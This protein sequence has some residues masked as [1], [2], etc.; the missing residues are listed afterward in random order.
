MIFGGTG[1]AAM[2]LVLAAGL[3][4]PGFAFVA[5]PVN[6]QVGANV[7]AAS[8]DERRA[9]GAY[10]QSASSLATVPNLTVNQDFGRG[11]TAIISGA[12]FAEDPESHYGITADGLDCRIYF[13]LVFHDGEEVA[14]ASFDTQVLPNGDLQLTIDRSKTPVPN[15]RTIN[16]LEPGEYGGATSFTFSEKGDNG[17]VG[18]HVGMLSPGFSIVVPAAPTLSDLAVER[19]GPN[20]AL[21][22]F[23]SDGVGWCL[24]DV[25]VEAVEGGGASLS[26]L[27][28]KQVVA[29]K[30]RFEI[31]L[32]R[33]EYVD[34]IAEGKL[35]LTAVYLSS[36][37][38]PFASGGSYSKVG[39]NAD[40]PDFLDIYPTDVPATRLGGASR[41]ATMQKIIAEGFGAADTENV[42]IAKASDFPDALAV[43]ALAGITDAAIAITNTDGLTAEVQAV[44]RDLAPSRVYVMGQEN[45]ISRNAAE[46][47][48]ALTGVVPMRLAGDN[49][50]AIS[51]AAYEEGTKVG[52][53]SK[54]AFIANAQNF[55][56][57]LAASP[58]AYVTKSPLFLSDPTIGLDEGTLAALASGAFDKVYLLGGPTSVPERVQTQLAAIGL[59]NAI[60]VTEPSELTSTDD[61]SVARLAGANR[62]VTSVLIAE[63]AL[64][65]TAA[66]QTPMSYDHTVVTRNDL[67]FDALS[68]GA[69]AG[70]L[71]AP[72]VLANKQGGQGNYI[73]DNFFKAHGPQIGHIYALGDENSLPKGLLALMESARCFGVS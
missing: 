43:A 52:A 22:S 47:I 20:E 38:V 57:A 64:R 29:G 59:A 3:C 28:E 41:H 4:I 42:I 48:T 53:W 13:L 35:R 50:I 24:I 36:D 70:R 49:R 15:G 14:D 25:Y 1:K 54:T 44:L 37:E 60:A 62:D 58:F 26:A 6:G 67:S 34:P 56:D 45:S 17:S 5:E 73:L 10:A 8:P 61:Y 68:G 39:P 11:S 21:I 7:A 46:Q 31:K 32:A 71:R 51:L 19:T 55:P 33:A 65:Q 12:I 66:T 27:E 9:A 40:I 18:D 63:E 69:L 2:A 30:N 72:L 23:N 16:D